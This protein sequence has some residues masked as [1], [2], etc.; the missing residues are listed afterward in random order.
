MVPASRKTDVASHQSFPDLSAR[1]WVSKME[2]RLCWA[3]LSVAGF[4]LLLFLLDLI[5]KIPFGRPS[6]VV[7][8]FIVAASGL[9]LYLSWDALKDLL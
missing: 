9:V 7:D 3:S 6:L 2:K 4:L 8:I 5:I 1:G